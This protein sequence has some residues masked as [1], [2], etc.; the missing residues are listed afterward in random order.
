MPE[1]NRAVKPPATRRARFVSR[2]ERQ[3]Q[4][5]YE[6]AAGPVSTALFRLTVPFHFLLSAWP[7]PHVR[8]PAAAGAMLVNRVNMSWKDP[9]HPLRYWGPRRAE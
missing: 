2:A 1:I 6:L 4:I 3:K 5:Q 8:C 7:Q 9:G